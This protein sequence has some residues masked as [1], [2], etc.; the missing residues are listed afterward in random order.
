PKA[1]PKAKRKEP[2]GQ[3]LYDEVMPYAEDAIKAYNERAGTNYQLVEP[4]EITHV[5]TSKCFI[6]HIDFTAQNTD[7]AAAPV[8]MF[9]AE[10]TTNKVT[11]VQLCVCMGP[12]KSIRGDKNN[13]CCFCKYHNVQHPR[14]GG[15][16]TDSTA[17]FG[18]NS[19]AS[20]R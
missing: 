7:V 20:W 9:F 15:F 4:G 1:Q 8:E 10:L 18:E 3:N 12:K 5:V 11:C 19:L 16:M 17:L 14:T 13:G 2:E 6:H